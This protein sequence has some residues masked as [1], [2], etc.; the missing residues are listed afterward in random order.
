[1]AKLYFKYGAMG[2]GKTLDCIRT[3][4][5]YKERGMTAKVFK[6]SIDTRSKSD[7]IESRTGEK[8]ES[9]SINSTDEILVKFKDFVESEIDVI[10]IDESQWLTAKQVQDLKDFALDK[11]IPV[12][13]YGLLTDFQSHLFEGSKRLI[14]L[15]DRKDEI[16]SIC[17]CGKLATQNAR[18]VEVEENGIILK[19]VIKEGVQTLVGG[20][21]S[22]IPLCYRHFRDENLGNK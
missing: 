14:E 7:F 20:N 4:Y 3:Y 19:K 18:I 10:I 6:P 9:K 5:N 16:K 22:Y 15:A 1:M 13:C 8:I 2:G 17:W 12:I 11:N 21:E